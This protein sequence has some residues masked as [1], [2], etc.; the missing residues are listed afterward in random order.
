MQRWKSIKV[1][2]IWQAGIEGE[3]QSIEDCKRVFT[4]PGKDVYDLFITEPYEGV[5]ALYSKRWD[6]YKSVEEVH[7]AATNALAAINGIIRVFDGVSPLSI[8]TIYHWPPV[9]TPSMQRL[10]TI[11]IAVTRALH[12]RI[13]PTSFRQLLN[14]CQDADIIYHLFREYDQY[15]WFAM[16]K[17]LEIMEDYV[18]GEKKLLRHPIASGIPL[19]KLKRIINSHRHFG[20]RFEKPSNSINL[21][22]VR[23]VIADMIIRLV[24]DL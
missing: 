10:T 14:V 7:Q 21:N 2:P 17:C 1:R 15:S 22:Q 18:G 16:Y 19:K 6:D 24:N 9:G 5:T 23:S 20:S 13:D 3:L 11:E 8:G 12:K 4:G